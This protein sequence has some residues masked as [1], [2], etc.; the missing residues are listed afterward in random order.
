MVLQQSIVAVAYHVFH[1]EAEYGAEC[2]NR[3]GSELTTVLKDLGVVLF[4][5]H[6]NSHAHVS[7]SQDD[8]QSG[9]EANKR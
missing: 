9:E 6:L 8:W 1:N 3:F 7:C 2:T 4:E 5:L